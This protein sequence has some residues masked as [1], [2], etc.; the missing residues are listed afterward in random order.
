MTIIWI[1]YTLYLVAIF[2]QVI[3]VFRREKHSLK[4][5]KEMVTGSVG[6]KVV[7]SAVTQMMKEEN[8]V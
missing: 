2:I 1:G 3:V 6:Y 5:A 8:K 4:K 7:S